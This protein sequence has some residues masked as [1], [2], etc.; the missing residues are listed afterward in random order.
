MP[1]STPHRRSGHGV[2]SPPLSKR[3]RITEL[4]KVQVQTFPQKELFP[5]EV[6]RWVA[7]LSAFPIEAIEFAFDNWRRNGRFFPVY[8][9]I[10]DLC[11]AWE[12]DSEKYPSGCSA[13]CKARHGRGYHWNDILKF[14]KLHDAK[15]A[16]INGPL[17]EPEIEA[18]F[19]EI[20]KERGSAPEWR[21]A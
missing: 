4:L 9:D 11:I 12:P 1:R 6:E 10:L 19:A 7:D 17:K 15:R 3:E 13:E 14:W 2:V 8:A 5:E 16:E 21:R 20:D 18:L